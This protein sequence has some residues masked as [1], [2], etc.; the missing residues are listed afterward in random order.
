MDIWQQIAPEFSKTEN[1]GVPGRVS[2]FLLLALSQLRRDLG[3]QVVIHNAFET[4]GHSE[5]SQHYNGGAVD[6]HLVTDLP[7]YRQILLVENFLERFQLASHCGFG[8][9]PSWNSPGFHLDAR[10]VKA[11]WGFDKQ[12]RSVAYNVAKDIARGMM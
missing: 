7:F 8:I 10:G 6:F 5:G 2:G 1:W 11:R 12:G 4:D 3:L 9:Y